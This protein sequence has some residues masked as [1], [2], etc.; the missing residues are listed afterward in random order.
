MPTSKIKLSYSDLLAWPDDG[1]RHELIDGEHIVSAAPTPRHQIVLANLFRHLDSFVR[2]H[3][4]GLV[5]F[6][7]VDVLLSDYDVLEPDL[8]YIAKP[9]LAIVEERYLGKAPD[10]AVEVL[11]PSTRRID[12]TAKRRVYRKF[13]VAEYWIVDPRDETVEVFRG[14]SE[15]FAPTARLTR[16]DTP[17]HLESPLF[18]GFALTAEAIFS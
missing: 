1:K 11:S 7:P 17:A 3:D 2:A 4:L 18:P 13:G 6:A 15:W 8:L 10:L 12:T 16:T 14:D 9:R 5:L